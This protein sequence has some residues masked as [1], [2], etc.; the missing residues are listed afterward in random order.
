MKR[1]SGE[2][3]LGILRCDLPLVFILGGCVQQGS[4][5]GLPT[6]EPQQGSACQFYHHRFWMKKKYTEYKN[7]N[8]DNAYDLRHS[9]NVKDP[10]LFIIRSWFKGT[11]DPMSILHL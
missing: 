6:V 10:K 2:V 9:L 1:S 8:R 11:L 3:K 7:Y 4:A 5:A